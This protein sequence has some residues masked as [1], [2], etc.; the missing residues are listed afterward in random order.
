MVPNMCV[1]DEFTYP[2]PVSSELKETRDGKYHQDKSSDSH[3]NSPIWDLLNLLRNR[4]EEL[5]RPKERCHWD[6]PSSESKRQ[7]HAIGERIADRSDQI[8]CLCRLGI[9][10]RNR[11]P[12]VRGKCRRHKR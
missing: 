11:P 7:K 5:K 12:V 2:L 9:K 1:S 8:R 3:T 6:A 10:C 4:L